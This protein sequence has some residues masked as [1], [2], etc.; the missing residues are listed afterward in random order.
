MCDIVSFGDVD[1]IIV[2]SQ[3]GEDFLPYRLPKNAQLFVPPRSKT[4]VVR[5]I[6]FLGKA[7][8]QE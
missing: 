1:F 6:D 5:N 2:F 3:R 7:K 4:D 8:V